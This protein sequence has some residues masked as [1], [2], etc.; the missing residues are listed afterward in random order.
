MPRRRPQRLHS[1]LKDSWPSK[2]TAVAA[3]LRAL[4]YGLAAIGALVLVIM[5]TPVV[6]LAAEA[7][8]TDWYGGNGEVLVVLGGSMLVPGTGPKAT[9]GDDTYL[10]CVYASWVLRG[11]RFRYVLVSGGDGLAPAMA[12][13]LVRNGVEPKSILTE[14]SAMTTYENALFTRRILE[15]LYHG[16][17][18]PEVV[19]LTSDYHSWRARRTFAHC[20][21]RA[22][23][24][25]VPDVIKRSGFVPYR[26]T[27][28]FTLLSE[29]EKDIFYTASGRA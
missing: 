8:E 18:V 16:R 28:A 1:L 6:R 21:L 9:L 13:F 5:F 15:A 12:A 3:A 26:L 19:V 7:T 22:Q 17:Q 11:Q 10:R 20:G 27:A 2:A 23:T 29:W 24:I 4:I 14:R 25:P